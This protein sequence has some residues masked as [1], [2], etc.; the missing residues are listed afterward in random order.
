MVHI[1]P[2]CIFAAAQLA[3][4]ARAHITLE[5]IDSLKSITKDCN[6]K[7]R[8]LKS[9][10]NGNPAQVAILNDQDSKDEIEDVVAG[11]LTYLDG[12]LLRLLNIPVKDI[13][14]EKPDCPV[15]VEHCHVFLEATTRFLQAVDEKQQE[16]GWDTESGIYSALGWMQSLWASRSAHNMYEIT[17][18]VT[19]MTLVSPGDNHKATMTSLQP[20]TTFT[21]RPPTFISRPH[22]QT[23]GI[24]GTGYEEWEIR[25]TILEFYV[26]LLSMTIMVLFVAL[27]AL[28][29]LDYLRPQYRGQ[30]RLSEKVL[31]Y[32][33]LKAER[34]KDKDEDEVTAVEPCG[35]ST[36]SRRGEDEDME[37][38]ELTGEQLGPN[39]PRRRN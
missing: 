10:H 28:L 21:Q 5:D 15:V 8:A 31:R 33:K 39:E 12:E 23:H 30:A 11:T 22:L 19:T 14:I 24:Y 36:T 6:D 7:I 27:L 2:L 38:R 18:L 16:F 4:V 3:W 20:Y 35:S 32:L 9:S 29:A 37:K 34:L 26:L 13:A 17:T 25:I 1:R